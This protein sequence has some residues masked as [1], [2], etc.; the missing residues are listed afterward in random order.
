MSFELGDKARRTLSLVTIALAW[1]ASGCA[2]DGLGA[3]GG[4]SPGG[5]GAGGLGAPGGADS[6]GGPLGGGG[7]GGAPL[8]TTT[9]SV[10]EY[11]TSE[12]EPQVVMTSQGRVVAAWNAFNYDP[13][14]FYHLEYAISEDAGETWGSVVSIPLPDEDNIGSNVTLD[15]SDDGTVFMAYATEYVNP[16]GVRSA[17]RVFLLRLLP[18]DP[19]FEAP[20]QIT[21]PDAVVGVYDQPA[22]TVAQGGDIL[23]TYGEA[24]EDLGSLQLVVQRSTDGGVTFSRTV[25]IPSGGPQYMNLF[26]PCTS[27]DGADVYLLYV[28]SDLG[29]ALWAS[30][31]GGATFPEDQRVPVYDPADATHVSTM[32]DGNCVVDGDD[33]WVVYGTSSNPNGTSTRV[34]RLDH[35]V[36]SHSTDRGATFELHTRAEDSSVGPH[37]LLPRIASLGG[38]VLDLA[39]YEGEGQD[40][41]AATYRH[42]RS[43]DGGVS[44]EPSEPVF[45]P[46]VYDLTRDSEQWLGDYMDL[47]AAP[48]RRFG[49]FTDN[50]SGR[51]HIRFW[52][53]AVE[54]P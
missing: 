20:V 47:E 16:A 34:P 17:Q 21:D 49:V 51:G 12:H 11:S 22:V 24:P 8:I 13:T 54:D 43:F 5:G 42:A 6:G 40:D 19:T 27:G 44:F 7:D 4:S 1:T 23:V 38:G 50:A 53:V 35:V 41:A 52:S 15:T 37:Y 14:S 48:G 31:D 25:P 29:P 30:H 32:V 2:D 10:S 3:G 39:Y 26:H 36:V 46:L 9:I 18:S 33:V 28:D 45:G